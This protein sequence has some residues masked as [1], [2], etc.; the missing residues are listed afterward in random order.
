MRVRRPQSGAR[1]AFGWN[2]GGPDGGVRRRAWKAFEAFI[3]AL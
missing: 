2:S 1:C 3:A